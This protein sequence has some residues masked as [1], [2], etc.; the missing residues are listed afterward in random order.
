MLYFSSSTLVLIISI[1]E[2]SLKI[3]E[4]HP[5]ILFDFFGNECV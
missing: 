2:K 5:L 3:N 4:F 1:Y